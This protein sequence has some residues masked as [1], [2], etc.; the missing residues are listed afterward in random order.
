[1]VENF[2]DALCSLLSEAENKDRFLESEGIELM[3]IMLK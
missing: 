3:I 2:F 1:M